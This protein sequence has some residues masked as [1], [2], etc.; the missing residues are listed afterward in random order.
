MAVTLTALEVAR[1]VRP[2]DAPKQASDL[3]LSDTDADILRR[4]GAGESVAAVATALSISE[5]RVRQVRD[6]GHR[7]DDLSVRAGKL[8]RV[9]SDIVTA[10]APDAPDDAHNEAALRVAAWLWERQAA[11]FEGLLTAH[12]E[13]LQGDKGAQSASYAQLPGAPSALR[14]SGAA[15]LLASYRVH[16][17][18]V[19]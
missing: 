14:A 13:T 12:S 9:V 5:A 4:L 8:L 11:R 6:A 3:T 7:L 19:C 15:A 17:L 1:T 16:R 18:G 2:N 10:F